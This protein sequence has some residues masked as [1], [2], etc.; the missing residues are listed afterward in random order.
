MRIPGCATDVL[1][2]I[3][4]V[5]P[6]SLHSFGGGTWLACWI[7]G[8]GEMEIEILRRTPGVVITSDAHEPTHLG[9]GTLK[10]WLAVRFIVD[11]DGAL[12][13]TPDDYGPEE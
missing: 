11:L 5:D 10:G 12:E 1:E 6:D 2:F 4:P 9:D 3:D 13:S 8:V 7:P